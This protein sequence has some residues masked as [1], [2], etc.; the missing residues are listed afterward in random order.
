MNVSLQVADS[1]PE[2]MWNQLNQLD[3]RIGLFEDEDDTEEQNCSST[4]V[5]GLE[6]MYFYKDFLI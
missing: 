5:C 1:L 6:I 2:E 4:N 3:R